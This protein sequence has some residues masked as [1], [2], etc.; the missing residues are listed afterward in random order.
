M[1]YAQRAPTSSTRTTTWGAAA[2]A[3]LGLAYWTNGDLDAADRWYTDGMA[4]L[5][6]AGYLSDLVGG[7]ITQADIRIAQGRLR[8]AM[9][10]Y[11]RGLQIATQQAGTV[12]RGAA[13]CT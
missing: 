13:T 1:A 6:K 8:E 10:R 5:E 4:S 11:E 7:A 3:L 2:A 9:S 12:L